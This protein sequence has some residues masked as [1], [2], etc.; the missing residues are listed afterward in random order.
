VGR[1]VD[2]D[3]LVGS[4]EIAERLGSDRATYVH[5]LKRR[6]PDFPKPVAELSAGK[7]W[8]W[9][10]VAAWARKTGRLK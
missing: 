2:V 5:D 10:D 3:E 9:S 6:H 8:A 4:R 7:V 1:K